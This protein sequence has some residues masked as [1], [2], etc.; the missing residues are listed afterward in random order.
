MNLLKIYDYQPQLFNIS[1]DAPP[2]SLSHAFRFPLTPFSS[3]TLSP[4]SLSKPAFK[5]L[6]VSKVE[7][8]FLGNKE[9]EDD[10]AKNLSEFEDLAPE[11]VVYQN[12]LRLVECSMFA[13]VTGLVY[14]LSN[15]LSIEVWFSLTKVNSQLGFSWLYLITRTLL[16]LLVNCGLMFFG[17]FSPFQ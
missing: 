4:L 15:S 1:R 16:L 9:E 17:V 6:C 14:F 12:T 3:S 10:D 5:I 13:A 7:A 8:S 11:S 2:H